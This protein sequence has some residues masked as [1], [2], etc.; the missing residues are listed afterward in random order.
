M[1]GAIKIER[2]RVLSERGEAAAKFP[3]IDRQ[4]LMMTWRDSRLIVCIYT[5]QDKKNFLIPCPD[6][7]ALQKFC[8]RNCGV[9]LH[10]YSNDCFLNAV[11]QA[12]LHTAPLARYVAEQ[13]DSTVCSEFFAC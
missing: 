9:G 5:F 1:N 13:H 2:K 4:N 8:G 10:N 6:S 11:L 3:V 12:M 7:F